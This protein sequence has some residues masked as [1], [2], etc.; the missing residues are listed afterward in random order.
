MPVKTYSSGMFV[1]LAFSLAISVDPDVLLVDE[2]LAVGDAVF[3]HRCL[4]RIRD[5]REKG[6]T[7]FL[8][9]HDTP[10][11]ANLCDRALLIHG[12]KLIA[13]GTPK[14]VIHRYLIQIAERLTRL[15]SGETTAG[16]FHTIG[17]HEA[18]LG[19]DSIS[20]AR[21]GSFEAH[22]LNCWVENEEG[23]RV[24]QV[25]SGSRVRLCME[26]RFDR[27]VAEPI[28][29]IMIRNRFGVEMFGTNTRL[30]Q[31]PVC[32]FHHGDYASVTFELPLLLDGGGYGVTFAVHAPDGNYYDY[33]ND[34]LV[35]EVVSAGDSGGLVRLPVEVRISKGRSNEQPEQDHPLTLA[36]TDASPRL[37]FSD[38][39]A[40]RFLSGEVR[41]Q[42]RDSQQVWSLQGEG[43]FILGGLSGTGAARFLRLSLLAASSQSVPIEAWADCFHLGAETISTG[44]DHV[45]WLLPDVYRQAN[46]VVAI[47]LRSECDSLTLRELVIVEDGQAAVS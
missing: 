19:T 24:N 28:F 3:V 35:V 42:S 32:A 40:A 21:F 30:R 13:D 23:Q 5:L 38:P 14:E 12:G 33:R 16:G 46:A 27:D 45:Q 34:A 36:F 39:N 8:V 10:T 44:D 43:R 47:R 25:L 26:V 17:A 20:E 4:T 15:D 29:G 6:V 31:D 22:I 11:V 9:T 1:R 2:A 7:I 37:L 41:Q 18:S